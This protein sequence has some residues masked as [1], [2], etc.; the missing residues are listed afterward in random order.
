MFLSI[1]VGIYCCIAYLMNLPKN[2]IFFTVF[3]VGIFSGFVDWR[4]IKSFKNNFSNILYI[5]TVILLIT[6]FSLENNLLVYSCFTICLGASFASIYDYFNN[7]E[8]DKHILSEEN[9]KLY[10]EKIDLVV[11]HKNLHTE[12]EKLNHNIL[13]I[14]SDLKIAKNEIH[15]LGMKKNETEIELKKSKVKL[16][17]LH[18]VSQEIESKRKILEREKAQI[19]EKEYLLTQEKNNLQK[20]ISLT[21]SNTS[22]I[23]KLQESLIIKNQDLESARKLESLKSQEWEKLEKE[24]TRAIAEINK[25][26]T[27]NRKLNES[28]NEYIKVLTDKEN[29]LKPLQVQDEFLTTWIDIEKLLKN[30]NQSNFE[31]VKQ[32]DLLFQQGELNFTLK[33]KLHDIRKRRNEVVHNKYEVPE[34]NENEVFEIKEIAQQLKQSLFT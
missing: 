9:N 21:Q 11:I 5:V 8:S 19:K 1:L 25:I 27:E 34:I 10:I 13:K 26:N 16:Q 31:S 12:N 4:K 32:I 29:S 17:N 7:L 3:I 24:N 23:K 6:F 20:Q 2:I 14:E 33:N 28:I 15:A 22:E 18:N 30:K